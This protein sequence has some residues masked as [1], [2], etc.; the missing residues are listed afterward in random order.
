MTNHN[1]NQ[2]N[3]KVRVMNQN[4]SK[5]LI[6]S[7]AEARALHAEIFALLGRME[8]LSNKISYKNIQDDLIRGEMDGGRWD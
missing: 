4:N 2:F 5:Q 1:I 8:E 7:A 6:L 3:E